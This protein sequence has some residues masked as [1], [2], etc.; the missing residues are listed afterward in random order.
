MIS[1]IKWSRRKFRGKEEDS[2]RKTKIKTKTKTN[3][4]ILL[5]ITF[6]VSHDC[7]FISNIFLISDL[8]RGLA[9]REKRGFFSYQRQQ[10]DYISSSGLDHRNCLNKQYI[11]VKHEM[12]IIY[13]NVIS[14]VL[15]G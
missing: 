4:S 15:I 12:F 1:T 9:D 7:D 3:I 5:K 2:K 13:I 8:C 10:Y 14:Q 11:D 6:R